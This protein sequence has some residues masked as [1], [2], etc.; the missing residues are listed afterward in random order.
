M[1]AYAERFAVGARVR[2]ASRSELDAFR[3]TWAF[4][5]PLIPEQLEFAGQEAIVAQV[6]FYHGGDP[7]YVL[8]DVPGVWHEACLAPL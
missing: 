3:K 1:P 7:L 8:T 5:N 4:H 2:I 6:G